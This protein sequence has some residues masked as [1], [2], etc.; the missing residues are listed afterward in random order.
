MTDDGRLDMTKGGKLEEDV[1]EVQRL[2]RRQGEWLA[3]AV[4]LRELSVSALSW[5]T[6]YNPGGR[7][8]EMCRCACVCMRMHACW[9][10]RGIEEARFGRAGLR[11]G[12][13]RAWAEMFPR[14][15]P[16]GGGM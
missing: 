14:A 11:E 12:V 2:P 6:D 16:P 13:G 9:Q 15:I 1:E 8:G 5:A 4:K 10:G 7:R 3:G